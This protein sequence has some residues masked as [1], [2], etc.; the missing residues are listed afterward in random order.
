[1]DTLSNGRVMVYNQQPATDGAGDAWR[2]R[3]DLRIGVATAAHENDPYAFGDVV[4]LAV[5]GDGGIVVADRLSSEIRVFGADGVFRHG[6]GRRGEGPGEFAFLAGIAWDEASGILWASD[7][8]HRR[9]LAF[10]ADGRL[11]SQ[12][13]HDGNPFSADIPWG[14]QADL[15][16]NIYDTAPG[17]SDEHLIRYATSA[18]GGLAVVDSLHLPMVEQRWYTIERGSLITQAV[19]PMEPALRMTVAPDGRIWLGRSDEFRI[20]EVSFLGDTVRTVQLNRTAER[21]RGRERDSIAAAARI[22]AGMLP[23]FKPVM[24]R[25]GVAPDG[26]IWIEAEAEGR[27]EGWELF[28]EAGRHRG[29]AV[30]PV[31]LYPKPWPVLGVGTVTGVAYHDLGVQQI[32]RLTLDAPG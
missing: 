8:I 4:S 11:L 26:W 3:E 28:D 29:R 7:V 21:L 17:M 1:M 25:I 6:F 20:H 22:A 31:P 19:V 12:H 30:S 5:T 32:V 13:D 24:G 14:G 10:N 23:R 15:S 18:S 27:I 16:G 9:Y 2:L